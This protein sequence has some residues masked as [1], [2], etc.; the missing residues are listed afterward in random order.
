MPRDTTLSH[1]KVK[2]AM[3]EEFI[4]LTS[5]SAGTKYEHFIHDYAIDNQSQTY[6]FIKNNEKP[7]KHCVCEAFFI[8]EKPAADE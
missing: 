2:K 4:L 6:F 5:R 1:E 3:K 8:P 7:R